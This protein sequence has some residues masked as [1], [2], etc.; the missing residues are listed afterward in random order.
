MKQFLFL[1]VLIMNVPYA[2]GQI[3]STKKSIAFYLQDRVEILDFA[4]PMEVFTY[5]GYE[6]FTVSLDEKLIKSQNILKIQTDYTI[7]NAPEAD[8]IAFF[9][10][11]SSVASKNRDVI[12]WVKNQSPVYYFSVC[13]GAFILAEAGILDGKTATTFHSA[14]NLL[15]EKYPKI[16][17]VK[18]VRFV[19]NGNIITTAGV[20]AG[21]DGA[22]HLVAKLQGLNKA[23]Q[24]AKYMEYDKWIPG[25]GLILSKDSP[26]MQITD[27]NKHLIPN[28]NIKKNKNSKNKNKSISKSVNTKNLKINYS[29]SNSELSQKELEITE[30]IGKGFETYNNLFG[31]KPRDTLNIEY[32]DFV[33]KIRHSSNLG[34]EADP[35]IIILNWSENTLF[36]SANWKT[37]LL[38]ELFHLWNAES[39][40]Y[41][42]GEEHWFNEGFTEFYT[43]QTAAK[44]GLISK[45]TILS[46]S[47]IP[48]GSY[49]GTERFDNLS[50]REAGKNNKNKFENYFLVYHGGWV[51]AMILDYDIRTKTNNEKNLDNLM[52]WLYENFLRTER[53]YDMDDIVEGIRIT[54]GLDYTNFFSKYVNGSEVIPVADYFDL[55]KALW[56]L[57]FNTKDKSKYSYLYET[58]G[59]ID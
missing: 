54:T 32:N 19:D 24:T 33:V 46:T 6:V 30:I 45:E 23:I 5:A 50:M 56:S 13:T 29:F 2:E 51:T 48:I 41:K 49:L 47:L 12:N 8:I 1:A 42:S 36:S 52:R 9:G 58:L 18:N 17:V 3:E 22:L 20:S 7:D 43:Y 26:Y 31:G 34:G 28:I 39:F 57:Q 4:G 15:E 11:N 27:S 59:I 55:G 53:L 25:E 38:H 21:I 35:K 40:R 14:I 44:L 37:V 10:G 16:D